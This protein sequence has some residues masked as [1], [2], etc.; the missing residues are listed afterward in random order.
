MQATSAKPTSLELVL[1]KARA[2]NRAALIGY[3]PAGFPTIDGCKAAIDVLIESGFD[4]VEIGYPYSDPVMDGPVIQEAA[5]QAL[6]NGVKAK[7]VLTTLEHA[8]AR[9]AAAVVMT[10]W[11]PIEQFGSDAFAQAIADAGG[12]GVIT[13]DLSFEQAQPWSASAAKAGINTIYVVA[14]STTDERLQK[15]TGITSGFIYA[16]SLMGV[17]GT[18]TS[19]S[20]SARELVARIRKVS[21]LPVAVGL[22]V[23]TPEQASEVATYADGVIIGSALIKELLGKDLESGLAGLRTLARSLSAATKSAHRAPQGVK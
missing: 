14:P 11:N 1:S 6:R 9:G 8:T 21:N 3:I 15:V 16:A 19:I 22:G 13:P 7:D 5:D 23:S 12:S 18:R 10:Y 2:E 4:A 20:N 17:T